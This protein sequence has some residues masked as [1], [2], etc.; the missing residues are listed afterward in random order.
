[1][2]AEAHPEEDPATV[3]P[4]RDRVDPVLAVLC[5]E[6]PGPRVQAAEWGLS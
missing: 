3:P 1:M 2:R 6:D 4:P 5:G